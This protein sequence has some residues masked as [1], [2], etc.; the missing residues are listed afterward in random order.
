MGPSKLFPAEFYTLRPDT[1]FLPPSSSSLFLP[2]ISSLDPYYNSSIN[3]GTSALFHLNHNPYRCHPV[4]RHPPLT[5]PVKFVVP[6]ITEDV[7]SDP[8][9]RFCFEDISAHEITNKF[10]D[11]K[12]S[13]NIC[14][15]NY[16]RIISEDDNSR[17]YVSEF[18][19]DVYLNSPSMKLPA[20]SLRST[21]I[22]DNYTNITAVKQAKKH[23]FENLPKI[24]K[25]NDKSQKFSPKDETSKK[26][27][28]NIQR[29]LVNPVASFVHHEQSCQSKESKS[30]PVYD[31]EQ[32]PSKKKTS[33]LDLTKFK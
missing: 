1:T 22:D 31:L 6:P 8:T 24:F 10:T 26:T 7:F 30:F 17:R 5:F 32:S 9:R 2:E 14:T 4:P 11:D 20:D 21:E 13:K 19:Q 23:L 27:Q 25:T 33:P 16:S 18:F 12:Q 28:S 15:D 29:F 3:N